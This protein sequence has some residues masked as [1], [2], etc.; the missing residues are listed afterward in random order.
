MTAKEQ[1]D[2][3]IS[4]AKMT[5]QDVANLF[6]VSPQAVGKWVSRGCPRNSD[7]TYHLTAVVRWVYS[8][9][10]SVSRM[11]HT[12]MT[13]IAGVSSVTLRDWVRRGCPRNADKSYDVPA[14]VAWR[15]EELKERIRQ[16]HETSEWE[17]ARIRKTS[18]A[19]DITEME[20]ARRR[21][22]L[23]D[24]RAAIGG[25]VARYHRIKGL[26]M[27]MIYRLPNYGLDA[28]QINRIRA[29]VTAMLQGLAEDQPALQLTA[30]QSKGM[31]KMLTIPKANERKP[32]T[33]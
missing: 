3:R 21:G 8:S 10:A 25:W 33:T 19:A 30:A 4:P 31:A 7:K 9:A 15:E 28:G 18:L 16:V 11:P 29:D 2:T 17:A 24:R 23:L 12:Q 32:K 5:R 6:D 14:V 13:E 22:E 20:V 27:G 1:A 26:L